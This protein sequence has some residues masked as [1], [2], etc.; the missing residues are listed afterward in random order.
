MA[1]NEARQHA[2]QEPAGVPHDADHQKR[3]TGLTQCPAPDA[4]EVAVGEPR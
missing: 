4:K 3:T 1:K 2:N